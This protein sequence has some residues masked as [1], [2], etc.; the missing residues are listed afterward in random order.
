MALERVMYR[1]RELTP[2]VRKQAI[3]YRRAHRVPWHGPPHRVGG[4]PLARVSDLRLWERMGST[5]FI[6][7]R[8]NICWSPG[9]SRSSSLAIRQ[10]PK[11]GTP[12]GICWS[13]GSRRSSM[14]TR[15]DRLKAELQRTL[16]GVPPSARL[17]VTHHALCFIVAPHL[18]IVIRNPEYGT[19]I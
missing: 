18:V 11:G 15:K 14:I 7:S 10:P 5:R 17:R 16:L 1:W 6:S 19:T 8:L 13:S 2:E 4:T 12:A 9:F 3:E